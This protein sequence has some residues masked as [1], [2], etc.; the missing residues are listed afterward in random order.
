MEIIGREAARAL[1]QSKFYTGRPCKHG[2][3]AQ[4]YV[5]SGACVTC[6]A[7]LSRPARPAVIVPPD[8]EA[9]GFTAIT[10]I[11]HHEDA[12]QL[13]DMAEALRLA[14]QIDH[15]V[16]IAARIAAVRATLTNGG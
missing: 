3:D 10:I 14:R 5:S 6:Q 7:I 13:Q 9:I 16:Q 11:V 12:K 15:D 8:Q 1:E 4:R 2:H